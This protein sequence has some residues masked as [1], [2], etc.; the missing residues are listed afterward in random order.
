M[1]LAF[2]RP[3]DC[4]VCAVRRATGPPGPF[5]LAQTIVINS[6]CFCHV[7]VT[8]TVQCRCLQLKKRW[9]RLRSSI[10]SARIAVRSMRRFER[11]L[12]RTASILGLGAQ[13]A[14][15]HFPPAKTNSCSNISFCG[16]PTAVGI[17]RHW[18][19]S[20]ADLTG[21]RRVAGFSLAYRAR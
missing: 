7:S 20:L 21:L 12:C 6:S 5:K 13:R 2:P 16:R 19:H 9:F 11:R 14:L 3:P 8:A 4:H 15:H 18:A 17:A 10:S 1:E